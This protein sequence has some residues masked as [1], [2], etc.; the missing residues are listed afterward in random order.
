LVVGVDGVARRDD[1]QCAQCIEEKVGDLPG[2]VNR[3]V[4]GKE[5]DDVYETQCEPWD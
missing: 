4:E 2:D 3:Y 1:A 5:D